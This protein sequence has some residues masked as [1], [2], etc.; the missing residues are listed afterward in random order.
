MDQP[1]RSDDFFEDEGESENE[2]LPSVIS[3][4]FSENETESDDSDDCSISLGSESSYS[5]EYDSEDSMIDFIDDS[6]VKDVEIYSDSDICES[7]ATSSNENESADDD[8]DDSDGSTDEFIDD[9]T[10]VGNDQLIEGGSLDDAIDAVDENTDEL[11]ESEDLESI[12]I[13]RKDASFKNRISEYI[14]KNVHHIDPKSFLEDAAPI[15]VKETKILLEK[16]LSLKIHTSLKLQ[17]K[18][19]VL[20]ENGEF[21]EEKMD[22]YFNMKSA[23]V[24]ILADLNDFFNN[25]VLSKTL[26]KVNDFQLEGSGWSLNEIDGLI[27]NNCKNECFNG[28]SYIELSKDIQSKKAVINIKNHDNKC[29]VWSVLAGIHY[30]N[31]QNNLE[32]VNHYKKHENELNMNNITYPVSIDQI[33]KFEEQNKDIS[34]NVYAYK[35]KKSGKKDKTNET[36]IFVY[37]IRLTDEVKDKHFHLLRITNINESTINDEEECN[38][39]INEELESFEINSHYCFIKSLSRLIQRQL[40]VKNRRKKYLCDRCLNYFYSMEKRESHMST[41]FMLNSTRVTLPSKEEKIIEFKNTEKQLDVPF[42]IYADTE[43]FLKPVTENESDGDNTT[44]TGAYQ[45]HIPHSIGYYLHSKYPDLMESH[46]NHFIKTAEE[47]D[48]ITWF[49]NQLKR[50]AGIAYPILHTNKRM[51]PLSVEK[52]QQFLNA[53]KCH[54]CEEKFEEVDRRVRDHSH[55]TGKFRGAAHELCNLRFQEPHM[56]PVVFHNLKY[57]L[58]LLI[59]KIAAIGAGNIHIIP[60][61]TENYISFTKYFNNNELT[62]ASQQESFKYSNRFAFRFIDSFRFLAE[63]LEALASNLVE[64]D[65]KIT[66]S[67]WQNLPDDQL[68]LLQRKGVYPYDYI[69]SEENLAETSLPPIEQFYNQLNDSNISQDEYELALTVWETFR[70]KTLQQYTDIYLKTDILLLADIFENF[71]QASLASYGLDP[72]HYFTLPSYSWD[73]MLKIT[74]AKIEL[75]H[76]DNIDQINFFE[77]GNS[78]TP[79]SFLFF[80][81]HSSNKLFFFSLNSYSRWNQP[82]LTTIR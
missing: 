13:V 6:N 78:E 21:C 11:S 23:V 79:M 45:R 44:I 31:I 56:I 32:R 4:D 1:I 52:Q 39:N 37:P 14:L 59:E 77:R 68:R 15:F 18:K 71:R 42:I 50:I 51:E 69:K 8:A 19:Q 40:R 61:S 74:K 76:S 33:D 35:W 58:H 17:F 5:E 36:D 7:C 25:Q 34:I 70:V 2:S 20:C 53:S 46:Y 29:F 30:K 12:K 72:A 22:R 62:Q 73:A 48:S 82:M 67:N 47:P 66:K 54:I 75:I 28:S 38:L 24:G 64:S 16:H 41:C 55:L 49:A 9:E 10:A 81:F 80:F 27:V 43:A 26:S 60:T 57:D 3:V 65:F 63:S